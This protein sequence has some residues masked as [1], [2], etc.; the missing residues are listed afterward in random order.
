MNFYVLSM[1]W[2]DMKYPKI[3]RDRLRKP[4]WS[5]MEFFLRMTK[6]DISPPCG[7]FGQKRI[8]SK[9]FLYL[10]ICATV[11]KIKS[12]SGDFRNTYG[13]SDKEKFL[14]SKKV[15]AILGDVMK[16]LK[17]LVKKNIS[18]QSINFLGGR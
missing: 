16:E 2:R 11:T 8:L 6:V 18:A 7:S 14:Y 5:Y 15:L 4:P 3:R 13:T 17:K 12:P 10:R 1:L 9:I